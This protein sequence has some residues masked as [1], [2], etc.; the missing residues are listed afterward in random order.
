MIGKSIPGIPSILCPHICG[1]YMA[2]CIASHIGISKR[3]LLLQ[4]LFVEIIASAGVW[5]PQQQTVDNGHCC[6]GRGGGGD[7]GFRTIKVKTGLF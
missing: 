4:Y 1:V 7:F 6:S 5:Y 2:Y 3:V